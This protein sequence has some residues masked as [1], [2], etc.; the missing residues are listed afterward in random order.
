MVYGYAWQGC[1]YDYWQN[2]RATGKL[3]SDETGLS[4]LA[5]LS[6]IEHKHKTDYLDYL[7]QVRRPPP[8]AL[9][10]PPD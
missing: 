9:R 5:K 2:L 8:A 10:R 4:G 1:A 7:K 3:L 6:A